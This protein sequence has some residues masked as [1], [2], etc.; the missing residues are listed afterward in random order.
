MDGEDIYRHPPIFFRNKER[1]SDYLCIQERITRKLLEAT[2]SRTVTEFLVKLVYGEDFHLPARLLHTKIGACRNGVL[3]LAS[4]VEKVESYNNFRGSELAR[5]IQ[6]LHHK[7][8]VMEARF[9]REGSP[10]IYITPPYWTH[11]ASN[12]EEGRS[13]LYSQLERDIMKTQICKSLR[14]LEPDELDDT[15]LY[16]IRAWWD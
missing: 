9:G 16:G 6:H 7:G 5:E 15:E 11:Q 13:R 10:V 12:Y 3:D 8:Y 1:K 4:A 14:Q 2:E